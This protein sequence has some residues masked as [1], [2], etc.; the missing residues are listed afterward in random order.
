MTLPT[1]VQRLTIYLG[2]TERHGT[3]PAYVEI[4]ERARRLGLSGATVLQGV[5]GFGGSALVH[6]RRRLAARADG[7]VVITVVD[8][9][10]QIE[11][12]LADVERFLRNGLTIRKQVQVVV[13]RSGAPT[14][15]E[16]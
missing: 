11:R 14:A 13:H 8:A 12:L 6:R 4:V 16:P 15:N 5:E 9:P 1:S 10:E 3:V 7:P 2:Q